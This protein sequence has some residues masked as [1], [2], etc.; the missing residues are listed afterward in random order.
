MTFEDGILT[1][2]KDGSDL[3]PRQ[4]AVMLLCNAEPRT[5]RGLAAIL[6]DR[7]SAIVRVIDRLS[8]DITPPLINRRAD[9]DDGRSVI[10]EITPAGRLFILKYIQ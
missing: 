1:L 8:R 2:V 9:P 7:T 4:L 5:V 3:I 6:G 10:V